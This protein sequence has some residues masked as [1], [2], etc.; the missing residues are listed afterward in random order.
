M[1]EA[2]KTLEE[3]VS[4]CPL[5]TELVRIILKLHILKRLR[6]KDLDNLWYC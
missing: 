1:K 4:K 3:V 2:L 6:W 5:S